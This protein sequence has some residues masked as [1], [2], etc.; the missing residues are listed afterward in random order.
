M[1][2]NGA[3]SMLLEKKILVKKSIFLSLGAEYQ[4]I[5]GEKQLEKIITTISMYRNL[6]LGEKGSIEEGGDLRR[7][8]FVDFPIMAKL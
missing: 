8:V 1:V 7:K 4:G 2:I 3:K 5:D 6:P